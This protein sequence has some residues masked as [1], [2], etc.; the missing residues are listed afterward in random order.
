MKNLM[1]VF[2]A[3]VLMIFVIFVADS[4]AAQELSLPPEIQN[5]LKKEGKLF[6]TVHDHT[7]FPTATVRLYWNTNDGY[8]YM[9]WTRVKKAAGDNIEFLNADLTTVLG[10]TWTSS[11]ETLEWRNI[12]LEMTLKAIQ[13]KYLG[14]PEETGPPDPSPSD[15]TPKT[16][17]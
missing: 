11:K 15:K 14:V 10:V 16:P 17:I 3:V 5:I 13:N 4:I 7:Y 2:G 6:D 8:A 9:L 12:P 1:K